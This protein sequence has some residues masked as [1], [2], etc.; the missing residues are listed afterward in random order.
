MT[1]IPD[2]VALVTDSVV[3]TDPSIH[4]SQRANALIAHRAWSTKSI[5]YGDQREP[6]VDEYGDDSLLEDGSEPDGPPR[7]SFSFALGLDHIKTASGD[8]FADVAAILDFLKTVS[9]EQGCES[10]V[11]VRYLSKPWFSEHITYV[12]EKAIDQTTIRQ[13]IERVA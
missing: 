7:W 5:Y 3:T 11:E 4:L 9:V 10:L 13:L 2:E 1:R 12:D 6:T 8:W